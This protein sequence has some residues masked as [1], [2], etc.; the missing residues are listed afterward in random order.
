MGETTVNDFSESG[1]SSV[2]VN[3]E[4]SYDSFRH[5]LTVGS[6][7]VGAT[8]E[9]FSLEGRLLA[10]RTIVSTETSIADMQPGVLLLR[11]SSRTVAPTV[12][13]VTR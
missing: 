11:V 9:V 1:I 2:V 10:L 6:E 8:L 7:A 12:L 5:V 4:A 13:K 3:S